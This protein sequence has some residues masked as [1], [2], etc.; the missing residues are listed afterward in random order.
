MRIE[1][2]RRLPRSGNAAVTVTGG[3]EVKLPASVAEDFGLYVGMELSDGQWNAVL[4]A[5]KEASARLRAVRILAASSVSRRELE[6][7]LCQKGEDPDCARDAAD[8]LQELQ[9][10]DDRETAIQLVRSAASRGYGRTRIKSILYEK[11]IPREFWEEALAQIPP[12]EDAV[13][14]FLRQRFADA[15]PDE[16]QIRKAADALARRGYS[17]GE[18]QAGLRRFRADADFEEPMD[19]MEEPE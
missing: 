1:S 16:K 14:R 7:R 19:T 8:W 4:D 17:W 13:D 11:G 3:E 9:L 6:R 10:L 15:E 18:I 5:G 2:L 12:M